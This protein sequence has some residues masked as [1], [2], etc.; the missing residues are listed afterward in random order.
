ML[1]YNRWYRSAI[2]GVLEALK[3]LTT[4]IDYSERDT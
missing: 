4:E 2:A 3:E 1:T